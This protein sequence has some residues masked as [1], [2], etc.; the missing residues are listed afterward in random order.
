MI[1]YTFGSGLNAESE[2]PAYLGRIKADV[3]YARGKGI[4]VGTYS[5]FSSRRIDDANDVINPKTGKTGGAIFGNA[6]CFGSNWGTNYFRK[7]TN[8]IAQTGLTLLEHDGP[9]P[10]DFCASTNHPGHAGLEDSQW[11]QWRMSYQLY[12]WCRANGHLREPAGLLLLRGRQQN[13][14]GVSR[15]QLVAPACPT[16]HPRPPEHLRRHLDQTPERRLDVRAAH[17][18]PRRRPRRDHRTPEGPPA[19]VRSP[20][21]QHARRRRP[22][23]LARAPPL[24]RPGNP[25]PRPQV[26][27]PGSNSTGTFWS[28]TSSTS[29]A[30]TAGTSTTWSTSIPPWKTAPSP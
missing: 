4:E 1:I 5:L 3:D 19:R 27:R 22:S 17:R 24:R 15:S 16:V 9:Y 28:P 13:R 14:H 20:P 10:G 25:R 8:F 18:V 12:S 7:L 26:G 30:P 2:D 6:P 21:R 29:A 11:A 23:L